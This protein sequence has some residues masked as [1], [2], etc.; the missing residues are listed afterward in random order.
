MLLQL[1]KLEIWRVQWPVRD[2]LP[3]SCNVIQPTQGQDAHWFQ[4]RVDEWEKEERAR[5][6][7][8]KQSLEKYVHTSIQTDGNFFMA[9]ALINPVQSKWAI[10]KEHGDHRFMKPQ[11]Q[12]LEGHSCWLYCLLS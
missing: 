5:E 11:H 3:V 7:E 9:S 8:K 10:R 12:T 1:F 4:V 2:T 6:W